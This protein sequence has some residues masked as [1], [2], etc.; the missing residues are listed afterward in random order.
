MFRSLV[1][2][3]MEAPILTETSSIVMPEARKRRITI[4]MSSPHFNE[5]PI[6]IVKACHPLA[7]V[8]FDDA[9][10]PF[11]TRIG[12]QLFNKSIKIRLFKDQFHIVGLFPHVHTRHSN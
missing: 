1:K 12:I 2:S 9:A 5:V 6:W 7:P 10:K 4:P 8:V 11:Y 3:P